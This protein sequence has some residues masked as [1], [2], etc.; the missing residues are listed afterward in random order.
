MSLLDWFG[1]ARGGWGEIRD[2]NINN[3]MCS[4]WGGKIFSAGF[5][6]FLAPLFRMEGLSGLSFCLIFAR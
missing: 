3:S 4:Y 1:R 6:A 2:G 5:G